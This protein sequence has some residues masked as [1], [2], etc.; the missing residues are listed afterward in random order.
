MKI[1][2]ISV[3]LGCETV[4]RD[5]VMLQGQV[6]SWTKAEELKEN[7]IIVDSYTKREKKFKASDEVDKAVLVYSIL[8]LRGVEV[9]RKKTHINPMDIELVKQDLTAIIHTDGT[10]TY[11]PAFPLTT[12]EVQEIIG[13]DVFTI[14]CVK[15][16]PQRWLTISLDPNQYGLKEKP[17]LNEKASKMFKRDLYGDVIFI[18]ENLVS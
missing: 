18:N 7:F 8:Y 5:V 9:L 6:D 2:A 11:L 13:T 14:K 17:M 4:Q 16:E 3:L 1:Y 15:D 12:P 10:V